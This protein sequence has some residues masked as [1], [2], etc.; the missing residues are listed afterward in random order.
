MR[1]TLMDDHTNFEISRKPLAPIVDQTPKLPAPYAL[2][3]DPT[4]ETQAD[5]LPH[6][7]TT[8]A[9]YTEDLVHRDDDED[10]SVTAILPV[11][12]LSMTPMLST[13]S[14]ILRNPG[15]ITDIV[16]LCPASI[17]ATVRHALRH[18]LY[19]SDVLI[20][21]DIDLSVWQPEVDAESAMMG[22]ARQLSA[23]AF[24]FLDSDGLTDLKSRN[25][26]FLT[27]PPIFTL[28]LG[29]RASDVSGND[30]VC[31]ASRTH[32]TAGFLAPPFVL[33]AELIPL[34][35]PEIDPKLGFWGSLGKKL[36]NNT[37]TAGVVYGTVQAGSYICSSEHKHTTFSSSN[38]ITP[39]PDQ[40]PFIDGPYLHG[41]D[42]GTFMFVFPSVKDL[43]MLYPVICRLQEE[44]HHTFSIVS[45]EE[46][47]TFVPV[48]VESEAFSHLEDCDIDITIVPDADTLDDMATSLW[49]WIVS[50]PLPPD[51]VVLPDQRHVTLDALE[52]M[53]GRHRDFD[54]P[55]IR[56]PRA[57]LP[58]CD[59]MGSLSLEEWLNWHV[60]QVDITIITDSRPASLSR[61]LNSLSSAH[62]FGDK[63][64]VRVN[65]EQTV[66]PETRRV[67]QGWQWNHGSISTNRRVIHGG[68]LPA[69]VESWYP[70]SNDSYGLILEDDVEVAPLFYAWVKMSVLKY[71]RSADRSAK[72]FGISLYQQKNLE[73][74][75]EGGRHRFSPRTTF[76]SVPGVRAHTPYLS[77]IPCSWGAVY[78]PE[79]WREFHDYLSVRLSGDLPS[80]GIDTIVA[81]GVR[82]NKWTRSWKKYFIEMAYL[83]GY[84]MLYPNFRDYVSLSTNHLEVGSHVK[85][86]PPEVYA[87]KRR[88][89]LHPLMKL[90]SVVPD[91]P[92]S[93]GLLDL[94]DHEMPSWDALP[95]LDL[96]GLLTDQQTLVKR[97]KQR[98]E[99]LFGC[100]SDGD[101]CFDVRAWLC[102]LEVDVS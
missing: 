47:E 78:F 81:P 92:T 91:I 41:D 54:A 10:H 79:H 15:R 33:P 85:D 72:L 94:P 66:D 11:T 32:A 43:R 22:I 9:L 99:Q 58:Y 30:F 61:L 89:F 48:D 96:L 5:F 64:D 26:G 36:S 69:V 31:F 53:R 4:N 57:D 20:Y 42:L 82:S 84:V 101:G 56:I 40:Q 62:M 37:G 59:W 60:P 45:P 80:L 87:Q 27:S 93:T 75:P 52:I 1:P 74:R 97:G 68:L 98:S 13:L 19:A 2:H 73:L 25:I 65:M 50:L 76:S 71:R 90:P 24:L 44:G 100:A 46:K 51:I 63:V 39:Y 8:L 88:L 21:V 18:L 86:Q 17:Q 55:L 28:P 14:V 38:D 34:H 16:L 67:V 3:L 6:Y 70:R 7:E 95:V 49:D 29:P 83:R 102:L 23:R 35:N 77:Q 12:H